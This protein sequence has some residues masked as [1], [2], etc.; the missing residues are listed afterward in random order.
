[1]IT[2]GINTASFEESIALLSGKKLLGE[3][4]WKGN[5]DETEKLLASICEL[6]EKS[7]ASF[8]EINKIVVVS[9]PGPFS[10]VRIGVTVANTLA[11]CL[12]AKLFGI[13][14]PEFWRQRAEISRIPGDAICMLHAGGNFVS[15]KG[16][17]LKSGVFHIAEALDIPDKPLVFFGDL[18]ENEF[19]EFKAR[20]KK[21][22]KF[23]KIE[24]L[25][26]FAQTLQAI[27]QSSLQKALIVVPK[28]W[29]PPNIT[30]P[31]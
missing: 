5:Y 26:K 12:K 3:K 21:S 20:K 19:G 2:L 4:S 6:L 31:K 11:F 22:W 23:I 9:G 25:K 15:R 28:Y 27:N 8:S 13:D 16:G 29:K 18:T 14:A 1:M 24:K 10:A 7:R 30:K 17:G